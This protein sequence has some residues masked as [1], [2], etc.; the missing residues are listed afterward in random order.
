VDISARRASSSELFSRPRY[1]T[2]ER[3]RPSISRYGPATR[4]YHLQRVQ[5]KALL[6]ECAAHQVRRGSA[7]VCQSTR[8]DSVRNIHGRHQERGPDESQRRVN[9]RRRHH[10]MQQ[11][12]IICSTRTALMMGS[13]SGQ[14]LGVSSRTWISRISNSG[15]RS[16]WLL[17]ASPLYPV[18]FIKPAL[19]Q[20]S[21][22][23]PLTGPPM[24]SPLSVE[25]ELPPSVRLL[26]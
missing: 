11:T 12:R 2:V 20:C 8:R 13:A 21:L 19:P 18:L 7:E 24:R 14:G 9:V 16:S 4:A 15:L 26:W 6:C 5:R 3:L 1:R 17:S 25:R 23:L 22:A 10:D